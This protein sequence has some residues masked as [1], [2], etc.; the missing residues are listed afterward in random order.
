MHH[1]EP[2][3]KPL[4]VAPLSE[5]DAREVCAWHYEGEYAVYNIPGWETVV[6]QRWG[7]ADEAVRVREFYSLRN[8]QG[9]L[10]G[11]FR[12]RPQDHCLLVSLGLKPECCG[13]GLGKAVLALIV[14][15]AKRAAPDRRLELEVRS[16]NRRAIVCYE[17][18]GFSVINTYFKETPV[19]NDIFIRMALIT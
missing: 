7:I 8:E 1:E 18:F 10:V 19:G 14:A 13:K 3:D 5:A 9:Q 4:H 12:L 2:I 6:S 16:F 17:R 11:F 15:E